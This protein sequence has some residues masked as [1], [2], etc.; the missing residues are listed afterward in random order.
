MPNRDDESVLA[1]YVILP[2]PIAAMSASI[3]QMVR[4]S[5]GGSATRK[6]EILDALV[7]HLEHQREWARIA[8]RAKRRPV[9]EEAA[10]SPLLKFARLACAER[11][12]GE[13]V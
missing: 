6:I 12:D 2:E 7:R 11:S 1:D 9:L 13:K 5:A 8:D 3:G 4:A 10:D